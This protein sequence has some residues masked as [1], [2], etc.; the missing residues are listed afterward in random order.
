M[1][2]YSILPVG[3]NPGRSDKGF[4]GSVGEGFA[5][6]VLDGAEDGATVGLGLESGIGTEV[7]ATEGL[8]VAAGFA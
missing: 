4:S 7:G 1:N 8:G 2:R 3:P 6:G 5:S